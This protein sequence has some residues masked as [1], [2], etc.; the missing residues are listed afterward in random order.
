M[1]IRAK[2]KVQ[3]WPIL[4]FTDWMKICLESP[5]YKGFY[6]LGGWTLD[7]L[8]EAENMFERF[9][10][11][12]KETN[13]DPL[14]SPKE[15][16]RTIPIYIHGDEGRGGVHRPIMIISCQPVIGSK[17]ESTTNSHGQPRPVQNMLCIRCLFDACL[18]HSTKS[19]SCQ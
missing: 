17:G 5:L 3:P 14:V 6:L 13:L 19:I 15:P 16:R 8:V 18:T 2:T 10:A 12:F 11:R 7:N 4:R 9:W 1:K